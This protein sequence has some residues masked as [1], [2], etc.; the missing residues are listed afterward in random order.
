MLNNILEAPFIDKS[1][2]GDEIAD[3]AAIV[4][5]SFPLATPIPIIDSPALVKIVRKFAKSKLTIPG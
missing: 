3:L 2:N 1:S 5:L 4:A